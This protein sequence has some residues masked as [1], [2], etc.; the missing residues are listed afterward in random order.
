MKFI[1]GK[2]FHEL[3]LSEESLL[4][5]VDTVRRAHMPH[6]VSD[7]VLREIDAQLKPESPREL[8]VVEKTLDT[9][10]KHEPT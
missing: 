4:V 6:L 7:P 10:R 2:R 3:T 5:I 9:G 1:N 8:S